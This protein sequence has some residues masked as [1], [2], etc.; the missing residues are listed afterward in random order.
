MLSVNGRSHVICHVLTLRVFGAPKKLRFW[1]DREK[2]LNQL[3]SLSWDELHKGHVQGA[4]E[5]PEVICIYKWAEFNS[6]D[7]LRVKRRC[8]LVVRLKANKC[9]QELLCYLSSYINFLN[10]R[11]FAR[12]F[13]LCVSAT[14]N[15]TTSKFVLIVLQTISLWLLL[16]GQLFLLSHLKVQAV[17]DVIYRLNKSRTY[18]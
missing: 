10:I 3:N 11:L 16:F 7:F 1:Q 5:L 2:V 14:D 13:G 18:I 12:V 9:Y 15:V 4:C 6:A 17:Q 8:Q